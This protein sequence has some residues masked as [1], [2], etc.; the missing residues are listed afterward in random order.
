MR[1]TAR[2]LTRTISRHRPRTS[3]RLKQLHPPDH[4]AG[5]VFR[6]SRPRLRI[7]EWPAG[8]TYRAGG[9]RNL[10]VVDKCTCDW[11]RASRRLRLP[12]DT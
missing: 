8:A 7:E 1:T 6:R 4:R 2:R 9:Q 3:K 12:R 5:S 10:L 11:E